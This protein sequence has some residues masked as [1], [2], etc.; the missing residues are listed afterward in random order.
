[1]YSAANKWVMWLISA[2]F[3]MQ[4]LNGTIIST[5]IPYIAK[6]MNERPLDMQV[7]VV[8]YMLTVEPDTPLAGMIERGELTAASDEECEE[9]YTIL[10]SLLS[11][12]GFEH[13]EISNFAKDPWMR[14][15]HNSNYWCGD[16]YLG[17]GPSAHSYDVKSRTATVSDIDKYIAGVGADS[18]YTTEQLSKHDRY[19]EYV[20]VSLRTSTGIQRDKMTQR[21]GVEGLLYFEY[22]ARDFLAHGFL[23]RQGNEYKIPPDKYM[24]SDAIIR[25]L[26]Y[27]ETE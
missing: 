6:S 25:E 4:M 5:A 12:A 14:S 1:M 23:I 18:I 13:Y 8:A 22:K 10:R 20:M 27:E 17:L 26:F 19:N 24:Q 11:D 16:G 15:R 9:Q 2:T 7:A 21:F 3:F